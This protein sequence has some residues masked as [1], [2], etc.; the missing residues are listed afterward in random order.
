MAHDFNQDIGCVRSPRKS[1]QWRHVLWRRGF[2]PRYRIVEYLASHEYERHVR[3]RHIVQQDIRSWTTSQVADMSHMFLKAG[4]QSRC[5]GSWT[6]S[7]VTNMRFMFAGAEAFNQDIGSW[8]TSQ[9]TRTC[10]TCLLAPRRLTRTSR[11]GAPPG[12]LTA[13]SNMFESATAWDMSFDHIDG[14][15]SVDGPPTA[16]LS[17]SGTPPDQMKDDDD[18][19][20]RRGRRRPCCRT[21]GH[22]RGSGGDDFQHVVNNN[23]LR[24]IGFDFEIFIFVAQFR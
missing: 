3:G 23:L 18:R 9:V 19:A 12:S 15:T 7:Q 14:T 8:T 17:V 11:A 22:P 4:I 13:S 20:A 16:W 21:H 1:R 5:I 24:S 2:Q 10:L 6:T